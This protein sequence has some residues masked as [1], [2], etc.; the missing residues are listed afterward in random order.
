MGQNQN[1]NP[2]RATDSER[3]AL[4]NDMKT[5]AD[6]F[7][8][9]AAGSLFATF[10]EHVQSPDGKVLRDFGAMVDGATNGL[11]SK[12]IKGMMAPDE[13]PAKNRTNGITIKE[14]KKH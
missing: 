8:K 3:E 11:L 1:Q 9:K 5:S 10:V 13:E 7:K 2:A 14:V 12:A 6:K 4:R